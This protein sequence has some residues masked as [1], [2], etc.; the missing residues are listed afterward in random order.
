VVTSAGRDVVTLTV[1]HGNPD[2]A[3]LGVV[4]YGLR[5]APVLKEK[6]G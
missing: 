5:V 1:F 2:V 3:V 6:E 4:A